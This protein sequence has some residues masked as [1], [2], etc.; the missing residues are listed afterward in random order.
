MKSNTNQLTLNWGNAKFLI[1]TNLTTTSAAGI[2]EKITGEKLSSGEILRRGK[3]G[4]F[5]IAYSCGILSLCL[6]NGTRTTRQWYHWDLSIEPRSI[7]QR[8][9]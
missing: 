6:S 5:E 8:F 7:S 1:A 2:I 3:S 4:K 9:A